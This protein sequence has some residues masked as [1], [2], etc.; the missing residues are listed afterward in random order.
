M[1]TYA[2]RRK[3]MG[4]NVIELDK[5]GYLITFSFEISYFLPQLNLPRI[6]TSV[7]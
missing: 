1:E 3:Q 2:S 5:K 6:V 7:A 4:K